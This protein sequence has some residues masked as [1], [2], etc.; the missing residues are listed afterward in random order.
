[1]IFFLYLQFI[2]LFPFTVNAVIFLVTIL[3]VSEEEEE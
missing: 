1:M 3:Y 2:F